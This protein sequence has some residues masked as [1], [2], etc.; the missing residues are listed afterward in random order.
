MEFE[1]HNSA[2][3]DIAEGIEGS[4]DDDHPI[5][6]EGHNLCELAHHFR[7][8]RRASDSMMSDISMK[9]LKKIVL[10]IGG[11][12][13]GR[14]SRPKIGKLLLDYVDK[15]HSS[16]TDELCPHFHFQVV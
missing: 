9:E 13:Q 5:I 7:T 10:F 4:T 8:A 11:V 2:Q 6:C 15:A 1:E 3:H 12:I 14:A 16:Q